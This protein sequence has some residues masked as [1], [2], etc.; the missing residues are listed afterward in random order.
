MPMNSSL[1]LVSVIIPA[2]NHE[3]YVQETISSIIKQT[4]QNLELIVIDDGSTD[5]TW[6]EINNLKGI[7]EKRFIRTIIK[8]QKNQGTCIT[9]NNLLSLATGEYVYIIASDDTAKLEAIQMLLAGMVSSD[10]VLTVGNNEIINSRSQQISWDKERNQ[11]S[12]GSGY[13]SFWEYL[14]DNNPQINKDLSNFGSYESLLKGNYI[15]NGPLIR[16]SALDKIEKFTPEA[17]LED[18]YMHLQLS[19]EGK[20]RFINKILLSYRWHNTNTI[21]NLQMIRQAGIQ[22]MTHE[23]KIINHFDKKQW[24]KTF[25]NT[26]YKEK[27]IFNLAFLKLY[28][29]RSFRGKKIILKLFGY[30]FILYKKDYL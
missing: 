11:I 21:K 19:K 9:L 15:P 30:K 20:Y 2:Y 3:K 5:N 27:Y 7:C 13:N 1:P 17:P 26:V 24:K 10:I 16:K 18:W 12:Y 25:Y 22:I 4:Y 28:K 29:Q 6:Q 8:R 14:K 23:E